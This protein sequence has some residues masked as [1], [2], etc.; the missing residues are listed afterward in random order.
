MIRP[1]EIESVELWDDQL[2]RLR[3]GVPRWT[4]NHCQAFDIGRRRLAE[5][6]AS[7]D[8]LVDAWLADGL[9]LAGSDLRDLVASV[10]MDAPPR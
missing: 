6:V 4:G 8:P 1:D 7:N 2:D 10:S 5:H 9:H 3:D